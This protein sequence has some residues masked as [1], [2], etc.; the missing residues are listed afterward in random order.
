[1]TPDHDDGRDVQTLSL[2]PDL[3]SLFAGAYG[4]THL[5]AMRKPTE[6][7][8]DPIYWSHVLWWVDEDHTPTWQEACERHRQLHEEGPTT[9]AFSI[10]NPFDDSG[11][12]TRVDHNRVKNLSAAR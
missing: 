10:R 3:E 4:G 11:A 1:M 7:V 9:S 2:W 8:K 5:A 6:W 12:I